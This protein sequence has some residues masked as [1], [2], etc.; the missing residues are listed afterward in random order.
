M[1]GSGRK[2]PH[3]KFADVERPAIDPKATP[4]SVRNGAAYFAPARD[5]T[6]L[7]MRHTRSMDK[8]VQPASSV[9]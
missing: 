5:A 1:S 2:L 3:E 8:S 6:P 4:V 7:R 9:A